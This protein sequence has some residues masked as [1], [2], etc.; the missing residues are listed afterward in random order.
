MKNKV[1]KLGLLAAMMVGGLNAAHASSSVDIQGAVGSV[2]CSV[3]LSETG[4]V[5]L[6]TAVPADF[7]VAN[8]LVKKQDLTA[9]LSNCSGMADGTSTPKLRI[10]SPQVSTMGNAIFTSEQNATFGIG[11]QEKSQATPIVNN[12]TVSLGDD[13]TA[14]TDLEGKI[15]SFEIGM[16][17]PSTVVKSGLAKA[18]LTFDYLYN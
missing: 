7:T 16:I 4:P 6:K 10:S 17:A 15:T 11:I 1:M 3:N 5:I 12:G 14:G 9:T 18:T 13:S 2:S 8:Q